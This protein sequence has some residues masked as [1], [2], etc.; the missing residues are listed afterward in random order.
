MT[1]VGKNSITII[2]KLYEDLEFY[3]VLLFR[4]RL[5]RLLF[6][7]LFRNLLAVWL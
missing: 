4:I 3:S 5:N 7:I 2:L 6:R 1:T